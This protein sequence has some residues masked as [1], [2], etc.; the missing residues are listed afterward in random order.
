MSYL[1]QIL[2]RFKD[3]ADEV[4]YELFIQ[5]NILEFTTLDVETFEDIY[6]ALFDDEVKDLIEFE[7]DIRVSEDS[8]DF[9]ERINILFAEVMESGKEG[10]SYVKFLAEIPKSQW[11]DIITQNVEEAKKGKMH[12]VF[13]FYNNLRKK[14]KVK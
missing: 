9:I 1:D 10:Y 14:E 3:N 8:E 6:F 7:K 5:N 11:S 2:D 12:R 4:V 13:E